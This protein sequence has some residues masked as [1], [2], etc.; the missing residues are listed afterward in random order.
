MS[1]SVI[2]TGTSGVPASDHYCD[3][4]A[5]YINGEYHNDMFSKEL[6]IRSAKYT[7]IFI[8]VE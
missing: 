6:V 7:M 3:Q 5:L 1:L 8:P 4:T 2:P